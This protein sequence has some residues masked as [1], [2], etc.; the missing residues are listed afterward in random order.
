[1]TEW[2]F[3][4]FS[5]RNSL[6]AILQSVPVLKQSKCTISTTCSNL[7]AEQFLDS[8]LWVNQSL[9]VFIYGM[10]IRT[11]LIITW[12]RIKKLTVG[13]CCRRVVHCASWTKQT[14]IK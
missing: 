14:A 10:K 2:H 13:I 1:M 6:R 11:L 4:N 5:F 8:F 3:R 9:V 12:E 7:M